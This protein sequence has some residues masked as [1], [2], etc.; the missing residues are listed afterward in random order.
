MS[1]NSNMLQWMDHEISLKNP[2][3]FFSNNMRLDINN[4]LCQDQEDDMFD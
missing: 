1:Y 2:D 4:Q 3:E